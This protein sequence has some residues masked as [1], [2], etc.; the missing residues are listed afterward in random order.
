MIEIK[1]GDFVVMSDCKP[2]HQFYQI[3]DDDIGSHWVRL[4]EMRHATAAEIKAHHRLDDNITDNVAD[5]KYHVSQNIRV[6][7][8]RA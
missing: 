6:S 4:V 3:T 1:S 2:E 5:I 7:G 8:E